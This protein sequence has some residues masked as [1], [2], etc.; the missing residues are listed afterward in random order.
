MNQDP[1]IKKYALI[2]VLVASFTTP[3]MGSAVNLAIPTIGQ[4]FDSSA[5]LLSWVVSSYLLSSAAFLLPFGRLADLVG[6]KKV[7]IMGV[8]IFSVSSLLCGLAWSIQALI[9]LR[10]L[11][12]VGSAMTFGTGMAILT[13]VYPPQERGRVLGFNVATVYTGLSLGPVLGGAMNQHLGWESIFFLNAVI[14]LAALV[15]ATKIKG[16]WAGARGESFDTTGS[17]LYMAGLVAFLYAFSSIA[18]SDTAKYILLAGLVLLVLFVWHELKSKSPLIDLKLFSRNVT[19][20]MSNLAALINYSATFAVTFVLSL[21]LQVV[22]G[23]SSSTAGMILLAQPVM[24][25]LLSP[26]AGTL[27][28]RV[29][30]RIVSSIGMALSAIGLFLLSFVVKETPV[31]LIVGNL[32][33]LGTGF[34]LFSSPNMNA[35]MGSVDKRFYGVASSTSGTMRL[36]GQAVSVAVATMIIDLYVGSAQL[37]PAVAE[38]LQRSSNVAFIVFAVT[39]VGGV[40]ASLA[41]GNMNRGETGGR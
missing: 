5:L 28:D 37:G 3:F 36:V 12:G 20:A 35:I 31:W 15:S 11:Q 8:L 7:F 6:R 34:A 17:V 25:A 23:Y 16:E 32:M 29:Q 30:P 10:L 13:S 33:V 38:Q 18:T 2:T 21:V 9:G 4:E 41:R 27:S 39:C 1:L 22:M 19:F 26:F 40:F 14:G 24:M